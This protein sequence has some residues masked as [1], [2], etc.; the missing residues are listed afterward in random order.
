MEVGALIQKEAGKKNVA[1]KEEEYI[2]LNVS[3]IH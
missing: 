3:H 1:E 2:E